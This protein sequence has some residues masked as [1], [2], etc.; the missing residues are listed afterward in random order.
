MHRIH[1]YHWP[2]IRYKLTSPSIRLPAFV[3]KRRSFSFFFLSWAA[4]WGKM[5]EEGILPHLR[6]IW[7]T[8]DLLRNCRLE[9]SKRG[10]V[11]ALRAAREKRTEGGR[12]KMRIY[13]RVS[14]RWSTSPRAADLYAHG[15]RFALFL[16]RQES[17]RVDLSGVTVRDNHRIPVR[18]GEA[19]LCLPNG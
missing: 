13:A 16:G 1:R 11:S 17:G 18:N 8:H 4:V 15:S 14:G 5:C 19:K 9:A 10:V 2:Q 12:Q 3:R 6:G 7:L